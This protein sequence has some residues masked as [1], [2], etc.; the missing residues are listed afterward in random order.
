MVCAASG[1]A[2][3]AILM[4]RPAFRSMKYG[5]MALE[6]RNTDLRFTS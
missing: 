6:V 4:M 1:P 5:A 3:E 2:M